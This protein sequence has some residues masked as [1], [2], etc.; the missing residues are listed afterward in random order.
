M[1]I[2]NKMGLTKSKYERQYNERILT[3]TIEKNQEINNL[4]FDI[5]RICGTMDNL[6]RRILTLE[7]R[8]N[9]LTLQLAENRKIMISTGEK[10]EANF[11]ERLNLV[12]KDMESLLNNDKLL[13]EKMIEKKMLSTISESTMEDENENQDEDS[14]IMHSVD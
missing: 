10:I 3:D 2:T 6:E 7:R 14:S 13:L 12:S 11:M 1:H 8:N 4:R 9:E 5:N